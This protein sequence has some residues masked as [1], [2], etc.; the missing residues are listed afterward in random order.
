MNRLVPLFVL[1]V[2]ALP[3]VGKAQST[4]F[5]IYSGW[6]TWVGVQYQVSGFRLGG[7]LA[8]AGL[9]AGADFIPFE[10]AIPAAP[11]FDL[12]WYAGAGASVGF[13][14]VSGS[15]G[16]YLF[17]H[18]LAGIEYAFPMQPFSLYAELQ[19]GFGVGLGNLSG[20]IGGLDFSARAGLIFR[21]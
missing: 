12:S 8:I 3:S 6:P 10:Q 17:P 16:V 4:G 19:V 21:P 2:L 1:L 13:W 20:V 14:T 18:G 15:S 9:A 7:G 11:G 5:G